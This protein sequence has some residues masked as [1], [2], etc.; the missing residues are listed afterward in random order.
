[1]LDEKTIAP[2]PRAED[3][4]ISVDFVERVAQAIEAGDVEA[5]RTLVG[6]LHEAVRLA[7]EQAGVAP[8]TTLRVVHLPEK[9]GLLASLLE[10]DKSH[11]P[12]AAALRWQLYRTVRQDLG[13]TVRFLQDGA[14][15]ASP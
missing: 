12:V 10:K 9:K 3:G 1:M 6:D 4:A 8:E 15:D 7:A 13:E 14:L 11:E 2:A 5:L